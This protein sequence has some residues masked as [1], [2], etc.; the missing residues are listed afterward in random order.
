M[1]KPLKKNLANIM[2]AI[3]EDDQYDFVCGVIK[4]KELI[5]DN[6]FMKAFDSIIDCFDPKNSSFAKKLIEE[7]KKKEITAQQISMLLFNSSQ[8]NYAKMKKA[9]KVI[10]RDNLIDLKEQDL[11]LAYKFVDIYQKKDINEITNEGKKSFL[12]ALISSNADLFESDEKSD[13]IYEFF[14]LLP[15]NSEE[16][17]ELVR[18]IVVSMGIE[19]NEIS[20]EQ[21]KDF[22]D[23]TISLAMDLANISDEEFNNLEINQEYSKD[24]FIIDVYN[25]VKDL[26]K[27]ER[28]KVYDYFGFEL[29]HNRN[30]VTVNEKGSR[31]SITG[32]PANLNNG[33]KLQSISDENTKAVVEQVRDLVIKFTE[34]NKISCNKLNIEQSLNEI[35]KTMP[36][37]RPLIGKVQH[38]THD[39][40][41]M[42]HSLK[43]M[44]KIIQNENFASLNDS[45][46]KLLLVASLLH[47]CTKAEGKRDGTHA[48]ESAFDT[49]YIFQK[50]NLTKDEE[51]K[52]YSLVKHHEWL[53]EVNKDFDTEAEEE[54]TIKSV[55]YDLHYGNLFEMAKI[56]TEADLKAVKKDDEFFERYQSIFNS[57][58]NEIRAWIYELK[59][60]QPLL[61]VTKL[62]SAS[63]IKEVIT[64]VKEDGS[65]NIK[66]VY[67][68]PDGIVILKFNEV[69]EWE[70]LGFPKGSISKGIQT[71]GAGDENIN[72]GNIK[73]FVHGLETEKDL[74]KFD[75]FALPDSDALLSVSYAERPESKYRFFRSKGVIINAD[76]KYV[77]G[78]GKTD[79]GSGCNKNIDNFKEDYA[80]AHSKRYED[81]IF[82]SDLIKEK[83]K[84]N[85]EEYMNLVQANVNKP[86]TEIEPKEYQEAIVKA[87]A[88]INSH[89]RHGQRSYNEMYLSNPEVEGL[90]AYNE[91]EFY[92]GIDVVNFINKSE[93]Y[94]KQ[95]ALEK[96]VPFVFFGK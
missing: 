59:R 65:T 17:C 12:K 64:E 26:N 34:N 36:E 1:T 16:Y 92:G 27:N 23:A 88:T 77:H 4:D 43:V 96:D 50:L 83:L 19:T 86:I 14:P 8:I 22:Y 47:D 13:K 15:K 89:V 39:F 30:G 54:K 24:E 87:L 40:D 73:F 11:T 45:D 31:Y 3:E 93:K 38:R 95:Y 25:L 91:N 57:K 6:D 81:R 28:Q 2:H 20:P 35:I 42:K 85:N 33:N 75:A 62:P 48:I 82:V 63:R 9:N 60:T 94:L 44:Q 32:Y 49:F 66:G 68:T 58:S 61:P 21:E 90:F 72:T 78:G 52:L 7:Y 80:F 69:E 46:K 79:R 18:N 53:K 55:A 41:I 29:H 67:Q 74:R 37:I 10:G 51:I 56:F 5:N 84:L 70:K 71:T 76:A